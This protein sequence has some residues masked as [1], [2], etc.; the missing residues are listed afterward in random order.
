MKP[1]ILP[2]SLLLCATIGCPDSGIPDDDTSLPTDD[3]TSGSGDD[4]SEEDA[5]GDGFTEADGDCDDTDADVYP[6]ATEVCD[7]ADNDC[8]GLI[9]DGFPD[10]DGDGIDDCLDDECDPPSLVEARVEALQSCPWPGGTVAANPWDIVLEWSFPSDPSAGPLHQPVVVNLTNDNDDGVIDEA[11]VPEIV[12]GAIGTPTSDPS[13]NRIVAIHG[14]GSGIL[15]DLPG[16]AVPRGAAGGDLDGDG[17]AEIVV[18]YGHNDFGARAVAI[19]AEGVVLWESDGYFVDATISYEMTPTIADLDG[20]G[21]VEVVV[22][23]AVLDGETGQTE[24]D[25]TGFTYGCSTPLVADLDRD[26]TA[27]MIM[28]DVVFSHSGDIEWMLDDNFPAWHAL[29]SAVA[30]LDGDADGEVIVASGTVVTMYD[31]DGSVMDSINL[32]TGT[33][34]GPPCVADVD[35]DGDVEISL[36]IADL[37]APTLR[38]LDTVGNVLWTTSVQDRS[39]AAGCSAFDFNG[40][41]AY[42]VVFAGE[43]ALF[44]LDGT[45]GDVL[46]E[47]YEHNSPTI[48]EY[49]VIADV[50]ADGSAEIVVSCYRD[51]SDGPQHCRGIQVYGHASDEWP[52]A[53]PTW[54]VHDYAPMRLRTDGQVEPAAPA[55]WDRYNMFRARPPGDGLADLYPVLGEVCVASCEHGPIRVPWGVG[56]QGH[57]NVTGNVSVALYGLD[58][59][60]ETLIGVQSADGPQYGWQ[61]PG[62]MFELTP[63][64]WLDGI[65]I[66]VDDD[67]AGEG[68]VDECDESNN[69]VE[70][71]EH[72]CE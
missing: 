29:F 7:G 34:G 54:S 20:D 3:D 49:P 25:L 71:L 50:D 72:L 58:G 45:T 31:A 53:G 47:W 39:G 43:E 5:D 32:E 60:T 21:S 51:I 28:W 6:G 68:A 10:S 63:E 70:L 52:P 67:G 57:V 15:F 9:D 36:I 4:T 18:C 42:E 44:V 30:N 40:D 16:Y 8:N 19:T 12:F 65:R 37:D 59:D 55:W 2:L 48:Y 27:E 61:E 66:V 64:Q 33:V 35:G 14:D 17:V 41:G 1:W 13:V 62:G 46:F 56:N 24:F 26:G 69:E 22:G 38:T 23:W 11:D